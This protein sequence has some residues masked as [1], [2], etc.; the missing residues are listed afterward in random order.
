MLW[1][2]MHE[3]RTVLPLP[4]PVQMRSAAE[5]VRPY[6]RETARGPHREALPATVIRMLDSH[7]GGSVRRTRDM[8]RDSRR[9]CM[10]Y[11]MCVE[12]VCMA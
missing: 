7:P 4:S 8:R 6:Q 1:A 2:K 11:N 10:V 3:V 9:G 5:A 12:C